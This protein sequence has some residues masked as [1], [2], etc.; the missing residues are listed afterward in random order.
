MFVVDDVMNLIAL[1]LEQH[2]ELLYDA[3]SSVLLVLILW[4]V[5]AS[6]LRILRRLQDE[7]H[8]F[9]WSKTMSYV[10]VLAGFFGLGAIWVEDVRSL[11]TFLG[12][13]T[14]G[15]AIAM[16]D[17]LV[18]V[19]AWVFIVSRKPF[20]I[21][22]RI[23]VGE[24]TG[25]VIDLGILHFALMEVGNWVHADQSTGRIV[26]VPNSTVFNLPVANYTK[27]INYIWH[28]I[29]VHI[30]F[31]SNWQKAKQILSEIA[32]RHSMKVTEDAAEAIKHATRRFLIKYSPFTPIVYTRVE[33][34]GVQLTIR[35]LCSPRRRRSSEND[36]WEDILIAF[37]ETPDIRIAYPTQRFYTSPNN[38]SLLAATEH[39]S[40]VPPESIPSHD[41]P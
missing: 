28:E 14:A 7:S 11:A 2:P 15:V 36:I 1:Y 22:D 40:L 35:Y 33:R 20:E 3:F 32:E 37:Q 8:Y 17:V 24:T 4:G 13:L 31:E 5:Y 19:M 26:H 21:G 16:R 34:D 27:G 39:S 38:L 18:S 25:D 23:Q 9:Q 29:P 41:R 6:V 10:M 30:T 12:V